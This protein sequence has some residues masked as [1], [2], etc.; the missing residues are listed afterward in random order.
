MSVTTDLA[1]QSSKILLYANTKTTPLINN[2]GQYGANVNRL[3][4]VF[5]STSSTQHTAPSSSSSSS[6][7]SSSTSSSINL[8]TSPNMNAAPSTPTK[9]QPPPLP[10]KNKSKYL[11]LIN[12]Q[13][14]QQQQQQSS[15]LN[16]FVGGRSRSLSSRDTVLEN[17]AN[18]ILNKGVLVTTTTTPS[19]P[20]KINGIYIDQFLPNT[21]TLNNNSNNNKMKNGYLKGKL[22]FQ[23]SI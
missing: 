2:N 12:G 8:T 23:V 9:Q 17:D 10:P 11:N 3:K 5:F 6:S 21:S 15:D 1:P 18:A 13:Q 20:T 22:F 7:N 19:S 16:E 14:Q 4:S